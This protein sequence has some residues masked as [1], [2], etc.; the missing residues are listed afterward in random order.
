MCVTLLLA[1]SSGLI[2]QLCRHKVSFNSSAHSTRL[3]IDRLVTLLCPRAG[4][5]VTCDSRPTWK[6]RFSAC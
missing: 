4:K 1:L 2:N 3:C 5:D 6:Q